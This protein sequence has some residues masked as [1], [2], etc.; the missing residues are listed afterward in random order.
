MVYQRETASQFHK[1]NAWYDTA[2][3]TEVES[4]VKNGK[5]INVSNFS[6]VFVSYSSAIMVVDYE[7]ETIFLLPRYKYSPTTSKQRERFIR[8]NNLSD[9]KRIKVDGYKMFGLDY[10]YLY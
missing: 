7:N 5:V 6:T 9:Y 8:E 2:W 4:V 10:E 3:N 1:C